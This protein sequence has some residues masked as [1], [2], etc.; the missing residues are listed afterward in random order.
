[1]DK[2]TLRY[3]Y[4]TYFAGQYAKKEDM[5]YEALVEMAG[6]N[7][8]LCTEVISELVKEGLVEGIK[9]IETKAGYAVGQYQGKLK[10]TTKGIKEIL[11]LFPE[12]KKEIINDIKSDIENQKHK[13]VSLEDIINK[14]NERISKLSKKE[15]V[16]EIKEKILLLFW[17]YNIN[18]HNYNEG[19]ILHSEI[20][21]KIRKIVQHYYDGAISTLSKEAINELRLED[22]IK[23]RYEDK[24]SEIQINTLLTPKGIAHIKN[25]KAK[26]ESELK[27]YIEKNNIKI[28]NEVFKIQNIL[29]DI[30]DKTNTVQLQVAA[31]VMQNPSIQAAMKALENAPIN[32]IMQSINK[33]Y[34]PLYNESFLSNYDKL[35]N[36]INDSAKAISNNL[37]PDKKSLHEIMNDPPSNLFNELIKKQENKLEN[38]KINS[39]YIDNFKNLKNINID[40]TNIDKLLIIIGNNASGK[41]NIIEAISAIFR[42]VYTKK[43]SNPNFQYLIEYSILGNNISIGRNGNSIAYTKNLKPITRNIIIQEDLLPSKIIALYSGEETRLWEEYYESFYLQYIKDLSTDTYDTFGKK[44]LYI[45]K[46]YWN[47]ALLVLLL[48]NKEDHDDFIKNK[49]GINKDT[50]NIEIDFDLSFLKKNKSKELEGFIDEINPEH[51]ESKKYTLKEL[52]EIIKPDYNSEEQKYIEKYTEE[53][54]F[55]IF[56]Y[57]HMPKQQKIFKNIGIN[58]NDGL[59]ITSLSE[60]EKKYILIYTVV[61]ILA[62]EKSIV[63]M[64]EPD[65][66]IHEAGKKL[67]CDLFENYS[68]K[69][70]R[71]IIVTTHSPTLTHCI[72]DNHIIM[73]ERSSG[74]SSIIDVD[75]KT[76]IKKLTG[77]IWSEVQQNIFLD[78]TIP[79]LLFEGVGDI[80]YVKKAI[81][82]FKDEFPKLNNLDFLPFGGAT[83]ACEFVNEIKE[84]V[85][86]EKKIIMIFDRDDAGQ[87]GMG[88]CLPK[89]SFKEGVKNIKTYKNKDSGIIYLMLPMTEERKSMLSKN[90]KEKEL[91]F[92]IEDCF[93]NDLRKDIAQECINEANGFFNKYTKDLKEHIKKT[94]RKEEYHTS[95]NMLGFKP[96]LFKI[97]NIIE[98]KEPLEEV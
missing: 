40:F 37:N 31:E 11:N 2:Q 35:I 9:L 71:Q 67:L 38:F 83:N 15:K 56:V 6:D 39:I 44:M 73:L 82:L 45:N 28:P 78:S 42:E 95:E 22:Y 61:E 72:K 96:L 10:L 60:G 23:Y 29:T 41:S 48:S 47:I 63:L 74:C 20:K 5:D 89:G 87:E 85:N 92:L 81:E 66:H 54:L 46:Y 50:V 36:S 26:K 88:K 33:Y 1:M 59:N 69:Y 57:A 58:F 17:D 90:A 86:K 80:N 79:L 19:K 34:S 16:K 4:L 84:I 43:I 25:E 52:V 53:Q 93:S 30:Y 13:V 51:I 77:G 7:Y 68:N 8:E 21:S 97:Q 62:D 65:A 3:T 49:L 18:T 94:L 98:D 55:E 24:N 14:E 70:N 75:R 12:E 27:D 76:K 64:D 32:H 91:H